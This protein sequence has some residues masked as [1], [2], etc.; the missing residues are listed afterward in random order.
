MA[1]RPEDRFQSAGE[2]G[3]AALAAARDAGP[4]PPD[5]VPFPGAR[6]AV[7]GDAPTAA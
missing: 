3:H 6:R 7:D 2:L 5:A 1:V 4:E